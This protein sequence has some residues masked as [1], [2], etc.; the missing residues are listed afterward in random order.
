[1]MN[2]EVL[3]MRRYLQGLADRGIR[4]LYFSRSPDTFMADCAAVI[5]AHNGREA[6]IST[7]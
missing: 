3:R 4:V 2:S 7:E 6:K 5:V 1:M